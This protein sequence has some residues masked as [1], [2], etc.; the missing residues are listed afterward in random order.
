LLLAFHALQLFEL[1]LKLLTLLREPG[2]RL[3]VVYA[4]LYQ[5]LLQDGMCL[6][7]RI[8]PRSPFGIP[9]VRRRSLDQRSKI[10]CLD[11][12][13]NPDLFDPLL[14]I[15]A[16]I[17]HRSVL[18]L[19]VIGGPVIEADFRWKLGGK[20]CATVYLFEESFDIPYLL[21]RVSVCAEYRSVISLR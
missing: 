19:K 14:Q 2:K 5:L 12:D 16:P 17:Q 1:R 11:Q 10:S 3:G 15:P 13:G 4:L 21:L 18:A 7:S 6:A 20:C 8:R 9:G